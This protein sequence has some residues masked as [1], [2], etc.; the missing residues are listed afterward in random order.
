MA[1][2]TVAPMTPAELSD[3]RRRQLASYIAQRVEFGGEDVAAATRTAHDQHTQFFPG[4]QP[5]PGHQLFVGRDPDGRQV[6]L[7]WLYERPEPQTR[8]VFVYD[9][10]VE[11][12]ARGCGWGRELMNFADSWSRARGATRVELN[13]FGGNAIARHLYTSL[14]YVES[15]VH[16][17]KRLTE[18]SA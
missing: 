10:E 2:L 1:E 17:V 8:S 12:A 13:V 14:G 16:M 3:F 5:A 11:E 18:E 4:G 7:I 6:G 15:A 9:V